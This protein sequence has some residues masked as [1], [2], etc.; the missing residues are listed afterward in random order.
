MGFLVKSCRI[1]HGLGI[2][3]VRDGFSNGYTRV[4]N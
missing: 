4:A 3:S 1:V 2:L